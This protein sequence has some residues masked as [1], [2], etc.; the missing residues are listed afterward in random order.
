MQAKLTN[1]FDS[2]TRQV[3]ALRQTPL[4]KD[5][6]DATSNDNWGVANSALIELARATND[7]SSYAIVMKGVWEGIADKKDKWRRIYKSLVLL[8][9]C[10]KNGS[11]RCGEEARSELHKLRPLA[12]FKFM[13]EGRDKGAGVREKSK[14]LVDLLTDAELL[15]A[16]KAKAR[17]SK[18]KYVGISS[19]AAGGQTVVAPSGYAG[20]VSS[21]AAYTSSAQPVISTS[22]A[23]PEVNGTSKLEEYREKERLRTVKAPVVA[24]S[25][26]IVVKPPPTRKVENRV[27]SSSSGSSSSEDTKGGNL[28][29]FDS[30]AKPVVSRN[31]YIQS[32]PNATPPNN[33]YASPVQATVNPYPAYPNP[34]YAQVT[35]GYAQTAYAQGI[36]V[37]SQS[38]PAYGHAAPVYTQS[39]PAYAQ[40]V[41]AYGQQGAYSQA[42]PYA[43][44]YAQTAAFAQPSAYAQAAP[45]YGQT[46]MAAPAYVQS[47]PNPPS[48]PGYNPFAF[49]GL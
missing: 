6:T 17:E 30:P 40:S 16:E 25:G 43:P 45:V 31:P 36:P 48:N 42:A 26:K 11:D 47:P 41:P 27:S 13:E 5:V 7:Y 8:E 23:P 39:V 9:Y 14:Q 1:A 37:Q 49:N 20:N 4:E 44:P 28:I 18:E 19:N 38:V 46:P 35:P 29:D 2:L 15:K 12:D 24:P 10:I 32:A 3:K 34:A 22:S 33:P 21:V